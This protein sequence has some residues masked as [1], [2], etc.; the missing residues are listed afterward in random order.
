M[1]LRFVCSLFLSCFVS[2]GKVLYSGIC[3]VC[4]KGQSIGEKDGVREERAR[5]V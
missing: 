2:K 3:E 4:I 1:E 5:E